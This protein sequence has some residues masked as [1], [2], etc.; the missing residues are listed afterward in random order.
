V[1]SG[2]LISEVCCYSGERSC[3]RAGEGTICC[4][5]GTRCPDKAL[6]EAFACVSL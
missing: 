6:G 3:T 1:E 4:P 2:V 5:A